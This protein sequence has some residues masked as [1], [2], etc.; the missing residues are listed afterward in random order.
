MFPLQTVVIKASNIDRNRDYFK[1][2]SN[3]STRLHCFGALHELL[4]NPEHYNTSF[5]GLTRINREPVCI[6]SI[7]I[8]TS[9]EQNTSFIDKKLPT[10]YSEIMAYT[11]NDHRNKG[12]AHRTTSV[13]LERLNINKNDNI[14]VYSCRMKNI[15]DKLGYRVVNRHEN[16]P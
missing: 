2:V 6:V 16:T 13:L 1:I 4:C 3:N 12:L 8:N 15:L 9:F 10:P 5:F 14:Y 7:T 11:A